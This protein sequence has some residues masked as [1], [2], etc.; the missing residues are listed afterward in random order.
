M[1]LLW[2]EGNAAT[3]KGPGNIAGASRACA[4]YFVSRIVGCITCTV[5]GGS[6][7]YSVK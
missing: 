3:P 5:P 1:G 2:G 6:T 7:S 4:S